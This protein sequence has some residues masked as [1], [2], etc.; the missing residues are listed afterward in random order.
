MGRQAQL[1]V[2]MFAL[3]PWGDSLAIAEGL[4]ATGTSRD[5][6]SLA[7]AVTGSLLDHAKY[8]DSFHIQGRAD[9]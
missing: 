1:L 7:V 2:S 4:G 5:L 6:Q 8:D 3:N 9:L